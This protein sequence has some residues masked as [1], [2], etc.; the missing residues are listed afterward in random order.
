[1]T[2]QRRDIDGPGADSER[3]AGGGSGCGAADHRRAGIAERDHDDQRR[4][5]AAA[6]AEVRRQDRAQRRAVEAVL[7]AA[8]RAAEG[9]TQRAA[10]HDR[11]RRLRCAQHLRRRDPDA[12]PRPHRRQR[13]ALHQLQLD[14]AVLADARGADHRPQPSLGRLRRDLRA[15]DGLS[16]A[17]T[18]I[19]TRDKATIGRILKDNGYRTSWFGK[20]HNTPA[21]QASQDGPFDQWPIGMGFEYFYGFIGGDTNQWQPNLFRNTTA[22]LPVRRQS[23]AGT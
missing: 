7:A 14:G 10:D 23:A 6:A 3:R 16:R 1:M 18:A 4:P 8:R 5:A 21:F 11:R 20:D 15:G 12:E 13:P 2:T 9:R 19:I 22:D 17:T